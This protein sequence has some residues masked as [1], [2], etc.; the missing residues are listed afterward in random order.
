MQRQELEAMTRDELRV[1]A[2][3]KD[4]SGRGTMTKAELIDALA[5]AE[6][7]AG[8]DETHSEE[9][10]EVD[11]NVASLEMNVT[12]DESVVSQMAEEERRKLRH[13]QA[14]ENAEVGVIV[15]FLFDGKCRSAKIIKKSTKNKIMLLQ[16]SYGAEFKVPFDS[17]VWV[18]NGKRWPSG[19][20]KMLKGIK[21]GEEQY[22]GSNAS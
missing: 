7:V 15:A 21:D 16:T 5:G 18:K 8:D 19:V 20:Y 17:I 13:A 22:E 14:V 11:S 12:A 2:K 10:V 1:V 6:D 9:V 3:D 4:V